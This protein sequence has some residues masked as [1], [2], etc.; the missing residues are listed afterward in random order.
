MILP[1][2]FSFGAL[3]SLAWLGKVQYLFLS[4]LL[5]GRRLRLARRGDVWYHPHPTARTFLNVRII[6]LRVLA[7][8]PIV[9]LHLLRFAIG[10]RLSCFRWIVGPTCIRP[11]PDRGSPIIVWVIAPVISRPISRAN[12]DNYSAVESTMVSSPAPVSATSFRNCQ[13]K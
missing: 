3:H 2:Y 10:R 13:G 7:V 1:S 12:A 6:T 5:R 4:L 9:G 11:P 8:V